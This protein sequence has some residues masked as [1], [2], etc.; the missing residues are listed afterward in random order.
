MKFNVLLC[1]LPDEKLG[2]E[3][4]SKSLVNECFAQDMYEEKVDDLHHPHFCYGRG[5][6]ILYSK[7]DIFLLTRYATS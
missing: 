2:V 7:H 4:E 1:I 3:H 6:T 5:S